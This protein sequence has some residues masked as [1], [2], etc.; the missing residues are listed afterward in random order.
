MEISVT[1]QTVTV[2]E[3]V[4]D[5]FDEQPIDTAF[6]LPDYCPDIAAV[7]KCTVKPALLSRQQS[8]DRLV[9]D[10]VSTVQVLYL[11]DERRCVR[12]CEFT[13]PFT[14]SF[15]LKHP[16]AE[17]DTQ[18]S[19]RPDYVN[20]RA[21]SPRRLDVHGA[22]TVHLIR[23]KEQDKEVIS[24]FPAPTVFCKTETLC[25]TVLAASAEKSFTVSEVLE[26]GENRAP[27]QALLRSEATVATEDCRVISGK[28]ILK[29]ELRTRHL[30]VTNAETG[31]TECV[32]HAIPF[33]QVLDVP[34]ASEELLWD[35]L[36][37][38]TVCE[39]NITQNQNGEG[40]LIGM[41]AKLQASV[42]GY[43]TEEC[44]AATDAYSTECPLSLEKQPIEVSRLLAVN[45]SVCTVNVSTELPSE[46]I[47]R[48]HDV[49][50]E[51][52]PTGVRTEAEH[53]Y[54]DGHATVCMLA[55][56]ADGVMGYFE[57]TVDVSLPFDEVCDHTVATVCACETEYRQNGERLEL[58]LRITVK[59]RCYQNSR[60]LCVTEAALDE[61][62]AYAKQKA[63]VKIYY[64]DKGER[65][66]DIARRCR[67]GVERI[68][69]ENG[70]SGDELLQNTMLLIPY[71]G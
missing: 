10:G 43:R 38:P 33:Q 60:C 15:T 54:V 28:V 45:E 18:V 59:R 51:V 39:S 25:G 19:V 22:V 7:L 71:G 46:G 40:T 31:D 27:A 50:C 47:R 13:V 17:S 12:S 35:V 41:T 69:T 48:I 9:A 68:C 55:C 63:A 16:G 58:K 8:G 52:T 4:Q 20:C 21:V 42:R 2:H 36:V 6:V 29:G 61:S 44:C 53:T 62:A 23:T 26:L 56:D 34:Q 14:G 1:R 37:E 30:Y 11:D 3:T 5:E 49:R 24:A 65:L 67:T 66:W 70:I 32:R 64:A 57:R